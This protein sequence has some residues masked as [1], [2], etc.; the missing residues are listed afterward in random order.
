VFVPLSNLYLS[1]LKYEAVFCMLHDVLKRQQHWACVTNSLTHSLTQW[2]RF[3]VGRQ[4]VIKLVKKFI[5]LYGARHWSLSWARWIQSTP[6][7]AISVR[8]ITV[9]SSHLRLEV[10]SPM[11]AAS[12]LPS[13][14]PW[15]DQLN[16]IWWCLQV[17]MLLN[18]QSSSASC[19][20]LFLRSKYSPQHPVLKHLKCMSLP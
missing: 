5:A 20:F 10:I 8:P 9:S 17:K 1:S 11:R 19:L 3:L 12:P 18:M 14:P 13:Y 7:N 4:T 2:S 16:D 15:F 6:S